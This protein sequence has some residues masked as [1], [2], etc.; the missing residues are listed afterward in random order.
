MSGMLRVT[1]EVPFVIELRRGRFEVVVDGQ[2][3]GT[4]AHDE[5]VERPLEPGRHTVRITKGR[6]SSRKLAFDMA[7]GEVTGFR[8]YGTRIWPLYVASILIPSLAIS[9]RPIDAS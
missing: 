6:Y 5:V 8:C 1:R 3:A 9:L 7:D 4:L 2:G